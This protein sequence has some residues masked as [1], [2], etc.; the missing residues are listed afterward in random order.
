MRIVLQRVS[1]ASVTVDGE[2]VGEIKHGVCLLVG[3]APSDGEPEV[4][5]AV[6]KIVPLRIFGDDDAK[7]NLS[8]VDVGGEVL[9]VSQFTLLGDVKKG[10]RPSF[11]G[12]A[13]PEHAKRLID[14]MVRRL[15][16]MGVTAAEGVFGARMQV[17]LVND[18]PVTLVLDVERGIVS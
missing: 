5:A 2:V 16:E 13:G 11:T 14:L 9:V 8:L 17:Q 1:G 4:E 15:R 6:N 12:A 3:I 10:R 18:G 7:M